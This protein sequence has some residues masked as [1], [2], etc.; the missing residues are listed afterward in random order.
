MSGHAEAPNRIEVRLR[1]LAQLFNSMD[2]SPFPDRDLDLNEQILAQRPDHVGVGV[3][4]PEVGPQHAHHREGLVGMVVLG[5][6]A[7]A[8]RDQVSA[9]GGDQTFQA[10][11]AYEAASCG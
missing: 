4:V 8:Q 11:V 7:A 5:E 9:T 2:P 10:D 6:F 3:D 1:D